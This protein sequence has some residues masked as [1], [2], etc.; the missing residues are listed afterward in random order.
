MNAEITSPVSSETFNFARKLRDTGQVDQA[1][2]LVAPISFVNPDS[3]SELELQN[4]AE[5]THFFVS[6]ELT[7][8]SRASFRDQAAKVG[9]FQALNTPD[10]EISDQAADH[11]D[12]AQQGIRN[13]H[14][15]PKIQ[16]VAQKDASLDLQLERDRS[17]FLMLIAQMT[18]N[19]V[20]L[21]MAIRKMDQVIAKAQQNPLIQKTVKFE[22][23][24]LN[25]SNGLIPFKELKEAYSQAQAEA[26]NAQD[27]QTSADLASSYFQDSRSIL[28]PI[29]TARA[30]VNNIRAIKKD[31]N[32][33]NYLAQ[34]RAD[35]ILPKDRKIFWK[36]VRDQQISPEDQV[37]FQ[38]DLQTIF[39][40]PRT[41]AKTKTVEIPVKTQ[42]VI[43]QP[44]KP[45]EVVKKE[46]PVKQAELRV[47]PK[48]ISLGVAKTDATTL[49]AN[50][51]IRI[52]ATLP[53][54]LVRIFDIAATF[55]KP[56]YKDK[57][58][59]LIYE[60]SY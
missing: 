26:Q 8:A 49:E 32:M 46:I 1:V 5:M 34:E 60:R 35:R 22:K 14:N 53:D 56:E 13:I 25:F 7:L 54:Q 59:G 20:A 27:W 57:S 6:G 19:P 17:D 33:S 12:L 41:D 28:R 40:A 50:A 30:I 3:Q 9:F 42:V 51:T 15:H 43:Q 36:R 10:Q 2:E 16:E 47:D 44:E 21:E 39:E 11:L 24:R 48:K 37:T 45:K 52:K 31:P 29:E 38:N 23:A 55:V 4:T 58:G 18:G